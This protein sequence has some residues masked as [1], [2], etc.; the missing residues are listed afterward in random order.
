MDWFEH[1][2][3]FVGWVRKRRRCLCLARA[4]SAATTATTREHATTV[5]E[6]KKAS[7]FLVFAS[8]EETTTPAPPPPTSTT[9]SEK[10]LAWPTSLNMN[11]HLHKIPTPPMPVM[12]PM[13]SFTPLVD[14]ENANEV[15]LGQKKNTSCSC[16]DCNKLVKVIGEEFL[17]TLWKL[18]HQLRLQV[19][20]RS[21]SSAVITR[22]AAAGDP[23]S[24]I[25]PPIRWWNLQL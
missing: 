5:V 11:N 9:L 24:L 19:M 17:E 21:I 1:Y 25:L 22:T 7:W 12:Y 23:A 10:V 18:G 16:W 13:T 14:P 3:F 15:F 2:Y 20:L 4:H 6:K 8:P